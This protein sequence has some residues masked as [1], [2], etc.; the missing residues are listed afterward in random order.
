MQARNVVD[1]VY[2]EIAR[3]AEAER[4]APS[5]LGPAIAGGILA[6]LVGG[7]V[8][9]LIVIA[10]DYEVGFVAWGIG[11]L[12]GLAV[13]RFAGGRKGGP[14][15]VVAVV[16]GLLGIVLGKYISFAYFFREAVKQQFGEEIS[17]FDSAIFTAFRENLGD[18]F[19]GFDL[20]FAALAV[21]TAWRLTSPSGIRATGTLG[22]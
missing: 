6:A 21:L 8:W 13:V 1:T 12:A 11:F 16:S 4:Y 19:G 15:Q 9:G 3:L 17:Y 7:L 22:T 20:I 18:V 14:L 2:P 5:A 10:S